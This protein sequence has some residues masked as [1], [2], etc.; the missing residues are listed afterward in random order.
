MIGMEPFGANFFL[1]RAYVKLAGLAVKK[2][3]TVL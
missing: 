3:Q 2:Y 1:P